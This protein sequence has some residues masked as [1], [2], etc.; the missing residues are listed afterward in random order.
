MSD[1]QFVRALERIPQAYFTLGD[2]EKIFDRPRK[3]LSV[4]VCRLVKRDAI[5]RL[6][7]GV[8]QTHTQGSLLTHAA[9]QLYYPSYLSFES[10]LSRHGILSQIPYVLTFATPKRSKTVS[11]GAREVQYHQ[12]K[13]EYYFGYVQ[14]PDGAIAEPEK[15]ILDQLYMIDRGLSS[16]EVDEWSFAQIDKEKLLRYCV[17]FPQS[18]QRR[19]TLLL[20]L[21]GSY[22]VSIDGSQRVQA[23]T[24]S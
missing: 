23:K 24:E 1:Y 22:N 14:S 9:N 20:G 15:A 11:L 2:L 3:S 18:V 12:L 4:T 7:K 8:F 10:A 19:L 17:V 16:S 6:S 5:K 13:Q 21:I